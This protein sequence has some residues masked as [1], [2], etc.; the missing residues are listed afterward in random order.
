[1]SCVWGNNPKMSVENPEITCATSFQYAML[2][3]H[4]AMVS[5]GIALIMLLG[6]L[7][8]VFK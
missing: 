6:I 7:F 1:M 8:G 5:L 4:I 2:Y 3:Y